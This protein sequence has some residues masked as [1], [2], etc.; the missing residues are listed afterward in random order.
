MYCENCKEYRLSSSDEYCY[1]CG[2]KL[3]KDESIETDNQQIILEENP[4]TLFLLVSTILLV[5]S[6]IAMVRVPFSLLT[7]LFTLIAFIFSK[8]IKDKSSRGRLIYTLNL[9]ALSLSLIGIFFIIIL[10]L[11]GILSAFL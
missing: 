7:F 3:I 2:N 9:L 6:M 5:L 10:I 11:V 8:K 4:Y 1:K